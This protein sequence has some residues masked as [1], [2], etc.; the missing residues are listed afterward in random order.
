MV[1][2]F[3]L[4]ERFFTLRRRPSAA[5]PR[6]S[7]RPEFLALEDRLAP[8]GASFAAGA[9]EITRTLPLPPAMT[10]WVDPSAVTTNTVP[11]DD[12]LEATVDVTFTF[13]AS[14]LA[15]WADGPLLV[16]HNLFFEEDDAPPG[17]DDLIGASNV[18][19]TLPRNPLPPA[20]IT[21]V[22]RPPSFVTTLRPN[23]EGGEPGDTA[24]FKAC[25][26]DGFFTD[27]D[28]G[29][30]WLTAA[31]AGGVVAG[32]FPRGMRAEPPG[33]TYAAVAFAPHADPPAVA[34]MRI[35]TVTSDGTALTIH[36]SNN[37]GFTLSLASDDTLV[38][39]GEAGAATHF[40]PSVTFADQY[41]NG[42]MSVGTVSGSG[43]VW[44]A[45]GSSG[46][47]WLSSWV[48]TSTPPVL[49]GDGQSVTVFPSE[50]QEGTDALWLHF[51]VGSSL[52]VSFLITIDVVLPPPPV[53]ESVA[54]RAWN[55]ANR[56]GQQDAGE[57]GF[58][59]V[60]VSLFT[61]AH[62]RVARTSTDADG[63]YRFTNVTPGVY[64]VVIEKPR[65]YRFTSKGE[66]S[67]RSRDSDF[68]A[69]G[70]SALF[71][72]LAK[73]KKTLDAGFVLDL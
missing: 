13:T 72:L 53:E 33:T 10:T 14:E 67:D 15:T 32:G 23:I 66:G 49:P 39:P 35:Y 69:D 61:S 40:D 62:T 64:Y 71:S 5:R 41:A 28:S 46:D 59:G 54:G 3:G 60:L 70:V 63:N 48:R 21:R 27:T 7:Y 52:G 9:F 18:T 38:H 8:A 20:S 47:G 16:S 44:A 17:E 25:A 43:S 19:F 1:P 68:N 22:F 2:T 37:T 45:R 58:A 65:D 34:G 56:N 4:L 36:G 24:E 57:R 26:F 55:D 12:R 30:I 29:Q 31:G 51:P 11:Q 6:P 73:Q 42:A 50:L